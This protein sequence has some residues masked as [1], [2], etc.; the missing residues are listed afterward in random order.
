MRRW[1]VLTLL[2]ACSD[3]HL[4]GFATGEPPYGYDAAAERSLDASVAS[5]ASLDAD[6]RDAWTADR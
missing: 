5:D 6:L 3:D 2:A 1:L 4:P